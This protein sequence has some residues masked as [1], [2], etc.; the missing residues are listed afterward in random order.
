MDWSE[1]VAS[2]IQSTINTTR[3]REVQ[4]S[5]Q[6]CSKTMLHCKHTVESIHL[7]QRLDLNRPRPAPCWAP[8]RIGVCLVGGA[9]APSLSLLASSSGEHAVISCL[10]FGICGT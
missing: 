1:E 10:S 4:Q 3:S 5:T 8:R 9:A 6:Q 7:L 2:C